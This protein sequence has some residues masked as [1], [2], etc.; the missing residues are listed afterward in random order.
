MTANDLFLTCDDLVAAEQR[1]IMLRS[2]RHGVYVRTGRCEG[3]E[4]DEADRL[5]WDQVRLIARMPPRNFAECGVKLRLLCS[6]QGLDYPDDHSE[7]DNEACLR[8]VLKF[9]EA[10]VLM[11]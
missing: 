3:P 1:L 8:G 6:E 2:T 9:I 5:L 7:D 4:Y 11:R 10:V